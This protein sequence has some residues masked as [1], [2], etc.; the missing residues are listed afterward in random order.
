VEGFR[1]STYNA[2]PLE[3]AQALADCMKEFEQSVINQ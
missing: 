3:G 2:L 1:A